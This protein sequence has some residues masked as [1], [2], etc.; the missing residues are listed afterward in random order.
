MQIALTIDRFPYQ[1]RG[2]KV[3]ISRVMLFLKFKDIYD[4]KTY[5]LDRNN[6][7]P[8][9][10]YAKFGKALPVSIVVP[11]GTSV[12]GT[13]RSAPT[14]LNGTPF[15]SIA[16]RSDGK[17]G[18][19]QLVVTSNDISQIPDSLRNVNTNH[20]KPEVIEDIVMVCHYSA[21]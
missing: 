19:W 16:M 11:S 4:S 3:Q 8:L 2:R 20:L 12:P 14:L 10:D 1:Y 21:M 7:S 6:P 5:S 9:G 18:S 13:L 17:L 15:D